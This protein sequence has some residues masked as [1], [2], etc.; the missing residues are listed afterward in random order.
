MNILVT[1]VGAI[2]GYGILNSLKQS[3]YNL[4]LYGIDIYN[5][6]Y[7]KY[8]A[9]KFI[10]A[11]LAK[12]PDYIPFINNIVSKYNI[13]LIIPGIE[14]DLY[15]LWENKSKIKTKIVL[16]NDL[17]IKLSKNKYDTYT[18]LKQ[19]KF[20][21]LIPTLKTHDYYKCIKSLGTPFLFKPISSYAS[22]GIEIINNNEEFEFYK[23]KNTENFILQKII[24]DEDKE[25]TISLFGNGNGGFSDHIILK[26]YLSQ[27]G[28]TSKASYVEDSDIYLFISKLCDILKPVGPTNIQVRKENSKVYLLE[29]NP[30]ISSACSLRTKMGYNEPEM[31]IN[32]YLEQKEILPTKKKG[33]HAIRYINDFFYK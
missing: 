28:A 19:E 18:F 14:Q 5:T 6:A 33:F 32:Y 26:R 13:D 16:N 8:L 7:G 2:I 3:K 10:Q 25:Y 27:E 24:G 23:K 15:K 21:G 11:K 4:V 20:N 22:K 29:I 1:G 31:C 12:S 30:R 9:D 17:C